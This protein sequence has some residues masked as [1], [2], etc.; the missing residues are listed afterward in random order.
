LNTHELS[1]S[2][3]EVV[4]GEGL[5]PEIT[6]LTNKTTEGR[7]AVGTAKLCVRC[8]NA[9]G[10]QSVLEEGKTGETGRKKKEEKTFKTK[11]RGFLIWEILPQAANQKGEKNG[12]ES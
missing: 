5:G 4:I 12:G 2:R 11:T 1:S 6:H 3:A 8:T 9:A 10:N 7:K